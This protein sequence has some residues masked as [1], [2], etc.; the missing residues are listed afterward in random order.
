MKKTVLITGTSS[1]I[2][3]AAALLFAANGWNV[4]AT[5]RNPDAE[6]ELNALEGVKV[7]RLDVQDESSIYHAIADGIDAC[8]RIDALVN[9]AGYSS[10]GIFEATGAD[11]VQEQ[12]D[13]NVFG[14]M[15]VTRALLPHFRRHREGIIINLSSRGGLVGLPMISLYCATKH[16]LEGFTESLAFE[17]AAQ[18]IV[19]K[20]VE[21]S[22]GVTHTAFSA[23]MAAEHA[24]LADQPD[25]E[26]FAAR[27][28]AAFAG[29]R[30][31]R[32]VS[33]EEVAAVIYEAATDGKSRLRYFTGEDVGGF[34][35]A[36]RDL[37]DEAFLAFMRGRFPP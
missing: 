11:K 27:T 17:L 26:A 13:V 18:N 28:A 12:F 15:N 8:G 10:F 23:R 32:K 1:G 35:Q 20:L 6:I 25:Y 19:V 2:G 24:L 30:A 31:A 29:M 7:L 21:P 33:A 4:L 16:A 36:K 22:G 14:V 37:S 3:R 34:V 9:N 5:M